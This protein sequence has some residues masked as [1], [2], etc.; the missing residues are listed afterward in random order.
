MDVLWTKLLSRFPPKPRESVWVL[1]NM[2]ALMPIN[3]FTRSL[4]NAINEVNTEIL[5]LIYPDSF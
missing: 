4:K 3:C 5:I 1:K 2:T